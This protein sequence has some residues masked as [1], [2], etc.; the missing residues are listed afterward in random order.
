MKYFKPFLPEYCVFFVDVFFKFIMEHFPIT[1]IIFEVIQLLESIK[2]QKC[3]FCIHFTFTNHVLGRIGT[4]ILDQV[5]L[6]DI[7]FLSAMQSWV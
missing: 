5:H 6:E 4:Y 1:P 2:Y 3:Y 7:A